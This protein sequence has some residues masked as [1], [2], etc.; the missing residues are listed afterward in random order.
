MQRRSQIRH[1]QASTVIED[2]YGIILKEM[3]RSF[4]VHS[5]RISSVCLRVFHN[6]RAVTEYPRRRTIHCKSTVND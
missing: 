1:H 3:V 4:S 5:V 6:L 2:R